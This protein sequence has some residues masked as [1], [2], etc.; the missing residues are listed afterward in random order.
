MMNSQPA[1]FSPWQNAKSE[2]PEDGWRER[3]FA[4]EGVALKAFARTFL[5]HIVQVMTVV[6][7][8]ALAF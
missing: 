3:G 8:L 7:A 6:E 1:I 4:A 5:H 2:K